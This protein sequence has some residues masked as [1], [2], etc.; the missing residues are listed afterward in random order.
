[1]ETAI[2]ERVNRWLEGTYD[3]ETQTAI[4]RMQ[5][6]SPEELS[7]AFYKDLEFGTGGLRGI[8]GVGTNRMNKYTVAM[9]T[10]GL[11]NYLKQQFSTE[12]QKVVIAYDSRNNSAYFSEITADVLSA[13][14]VK[15]YVFDTITPT[16]EL[17]FAIRHLHCH[18]GI[19]ITAS[20]NPKEYNGYKVYWQDGGQLVAP[21]DHRII[22]EVKKITRFEEVRFER[23]A[24]NVSY[25]GEEVHQVYIERV[26]ALSM[27]PEIIRKQH[28]LKIVYTPLHGTGVYLVPR[29]L[30]AFGFSDVSLVEAQAVPDG[31]FSTVVSPNPEEIAAMS[32]A[33]EEAKERNADIV[34]ATDPDADRI[35]LA[36]K[37]KDQDYELLNGNMTLTLLIYYM[38]KEWKKKGKING[39][40]FVVKTIVTTELVRDIAQ[41]EGVACCDVL[42]GFKFIAE[43]IL[44]YEGEKEFIAGG[45]ESFGC[46]VGDFVRDKDAV[47]SCSILAEMAAWAKEQ[48]KTLYDVLIDIYMEYG[49]YKEHLISITKKGQQGS[50]EIKRM[51][52][53][54][55]SEPPKEINGSKVIRIDDILLLQSFD[56]RNNHKKSIHDLPQ[57]DV[58]QFFLAD[59][60]K[61]TVRPSGTEPKIKFYFSVKENLV[62]RNQFDAMHQKLTNKINNIIQSMKL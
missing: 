49:L 52:Q 36:V 43:K 62:N 3:E 7:D 54:Y 47:I 11:A 9:A 2:N 50:Q 56:C 55:R 39:R 5:A 13:N 33:I 46:L 51:M 8:M 25:I 42:T 38:L 37:K 15:V 45:E 53:S 60:S 24:E 32:M 61:I 34:L 29:A 19:V 10:Q 18:S 35:G 58:L 48:G 4:R 59:G 26:K 40:Q 27:H 1:M 57:S 31:N 44:H 30:R 28:D 21:H 14:G 23:K 17:S 6:N 16:P 22:T 41:K 20:H 12:V